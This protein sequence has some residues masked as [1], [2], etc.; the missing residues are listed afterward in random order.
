M[1][2]TLDYEQSLLDSIPVMSGRTEPT[3][4]RDTRC[5][6]SL[7]MTESFRVKLASDTIRHSEHGDF[8]GWFGWRNPLFL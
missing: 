2:V 6:L 7:T 3:R 8:V 4:A 1:F 5:G